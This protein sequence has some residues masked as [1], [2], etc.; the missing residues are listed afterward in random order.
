M[1]CQGSIKIIID[2]N[3][4]VRS[5]ENAFATIS[6]L[7]HCIPKVFSSSGIQAG[8]GFVQK[9]DTWVSDH[10]YGRTKFSFV[11]ATIKMDI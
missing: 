3:M 8:S 9:Q 6:L 11:S 2:I 7:A 5:D 4:P 1:L 10:S